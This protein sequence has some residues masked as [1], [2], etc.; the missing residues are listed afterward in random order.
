MKPD[1][2]YTYNNRW[3]AQV[4]GKSIFNTKKNYSDRVPVSAR[5]WANTTPPPI[6]WA[7]VPAC[8]KYE[9][10]FFERCGW[11]SEQKSASN[12]TEC[13]GCGWIITA[14]ST[15]T[16]DNDIQFNKNENGKKNCDSM[17]LFKIA[18][19]FRCSWIILFCVS[20]V[21]VVVV[22]AH[23]SVLIERKQ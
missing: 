21:F 23:C 2:R 1:S 5:Y 12:L 9:Y 13:C 8:I 11:R 14:D 10:E 16:I 15:T 3:R 18:H 4:L 6:C 17:T 22:A 20:Y 7:G 19:I